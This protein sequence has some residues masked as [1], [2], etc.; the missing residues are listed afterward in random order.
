M[1]EKDLLRLLKLKCTTDSCIHQKCIC[2]HCNR[3]HFPLKGSCL[4]TKG[5]R[6]I[7]PCIKFET[8]EEVNNEKRT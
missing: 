5:K 4:H 8:K 3:Y 6:I 1:R 2:G 7:C